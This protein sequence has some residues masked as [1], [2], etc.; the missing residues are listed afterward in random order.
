MLATNPPSVH[1]SQYDALGSHY[2]SVFKSLPSSAIETTNLHAA[3][4]PHIL[5]AH[6]LDLD[7]STGYY[8]RK[9]LEWGAASVVGV[10]LSA[11]MVAVANSQIPV[12]VGRER[13][14]FVVRD[15]LTLGRISLS[16]SNSNSNSDSDSGGVGAGQFTLITGAWVL[17][18]AASL[19][20]M[21]AMFTTIAANLCPTSDVFA[22]IVPPAVARADLDAL[23]HETNKLNKRSDR[24]AMMGFA[25]NYYERLES[26]DGWRTETM[27]GRE[28]EGDGRVAFRNYHLA[29]EVYEEGARR[30]G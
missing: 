16:N 20:E 6:V 15:A 5:G 18:Y 30:G 13:L 12:G 28:G 24:T 29:R 7:Y 8:S 25:R 14:R 21:T 17:N 19:S 22:G 1:P 10:D 27:A 3:I 2:T 11:E 26:G 23:A 9:L 4:V